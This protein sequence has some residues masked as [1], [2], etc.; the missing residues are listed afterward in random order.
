MARFVSF[1]L[2]LLSFAVSTLRAQDQ[3]PNVLWIFVEDMNDWLGCYGDELVQTPNIDALA[4]RGTRF[5]R[6]YM[7]AGVCSPTRSAVITGCWQTTTGT[8]NH[9]SSRGSDRI[10][11][12]KGV[13][14]LP[15]ILREAG[16][17]TF[18]YGKTDY[19][20]AH[21][22]KALYDWH[23]P[24]MNFDRIG[25]VSKLW[26]PAVAQKKRFFGQIQLR[27]GK[28][29]APAKMDRQKVSVPP[30][31]PDVPLVREE[32]AHHYDVIEKTD[33]EVGK[34]L[35]AL[36]QDGLLNNTVVF[37]FSDHG[38]RMHRHKQF[39]YEGGVRVPCIIAGPRVQTGVRQDPI[40]GIDLAATT[41]TIAGLPWPST[42]QSMDVFSDDY[43]R[44]YVV[45]ARDRC[46]YTIDK[47][48]AVTTKRY[49]YIKN[50]L[51]DRP[52]MQ[53]H[54][55]DPRPITKLMRQ[56]ARDGQLNAVQM[57]FYGDERP[58]EEFYDLQADPHQI[59]NLVGK[60]AATKELERHRG[61]LD[62]WIRTTKDRG[63][64]PESERGL[65]AV[66]EQWQG[67]CV[68]PEFTPIRAKIETE[69]ASK[70]RVLILGDSISMGYTP[71][72]KRLMAKDTLVMRP[73]E[74]CAGTTKG[75]ASID[76][77][78]EIGNGKFDVIWFNFGLHDLKHVQP[79]GKNSNNPKHLRQAEP[80]AYEAN[81]REIVA[82]LKATG[83]QLVFATT[84][85]IPKGGV[86]P[87]R[88]IEDSQRY[89]DI[90]RRVCKDNGVEV[91][92]LYAFAMKHQKTI[93]P[94]ADVHF[95]K[96]GSQ[97][98][99]QQVVAGLRAVLAR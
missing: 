78:L 59:H 46:D 95:T 80:A 25:S 40:S 41:L 22:A 4:A 68:N 82:K 5:A 73:K 27:G 55:R 47:I 19:N 75:I 62:V 87:H 89:N 24:N 51:T 67:K 48:R 92:D 96:E 12:P 35:A 56:M 32:I 8:H 14:P 54:Y 2:L 61:L 74:N 44:F 66:L 86:R 9:R 42:M 98:L 97:M 63:Q 28:N 3:R 26:Q 45:S 11:L 70:R 94:R 17:Y 50:Y 1:L 53:P 77:W 49:K 83:A 30:Y 31:Y 93:Q 16:Y 84:T 72:V 39:L 69:N 90:A 6:A 13:R 23:K 85:P 79:S 29:R 10:E 36:K 33:R 71:V 99:G 21:D 88:A 15:T 20:F 7:P 76:K 81:L 52:Y 65:R 91:H 64:Q 34:I 37:F 18:N 58:A 57:Q 43:D 38:Y 60:D